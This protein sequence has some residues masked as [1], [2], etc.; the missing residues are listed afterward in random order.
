MRRKKDGRLDENAEDKI[1]NMNTDTQVLVSLADVTKAT[2]QDKS[3]T[4]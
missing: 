1:K 4:S 2:C 3:E